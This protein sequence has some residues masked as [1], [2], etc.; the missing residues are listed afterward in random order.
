MGSSTAHSFLKGIFTILIINL[1]FLWVA[2]NLIGLCELLE[3][4]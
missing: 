2:Q 1:T 3:L 4:K